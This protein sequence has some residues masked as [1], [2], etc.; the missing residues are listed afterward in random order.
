MPKRN[1]GLQHKG[2]NQWSIDK[3]LKGI[4]RIFQRFEANSKEE[5]EVIFFEIVAAA[6]AK[7]ENID[8]GI[9]SFR[10]AATKYLQES[11][12]K[13]LSRDADSLRILDRFIGHYPLILSFY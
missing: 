1:P 4:G 3:R 5:A 13:S 11:T 7:K 2:G 9:H 10:A 12:K 6:K 8:H